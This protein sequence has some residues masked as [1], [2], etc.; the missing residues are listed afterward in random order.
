[1]GHSGGWPMTKGGSQKLSDAL[2]A[3]LTSL[4][5]RIVTGTPIT[6][7]G[8]L[9][10]ARAILVDVTPQQLLQLSGEQFPPSY[11]WELHKYQYGLGVLPCTA[12]FES[13]HD[14]TYRV[15]D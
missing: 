9:P 15:P 11:R 13:G 6:R 4:G 5:G 3:H 1:L 2:A 14:R 10:S 12:G 8:Q 7:L